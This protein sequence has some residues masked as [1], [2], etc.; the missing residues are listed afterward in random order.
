MKLRY[1][2]KLSGVLV[3]VGNGISVVLVDDLFEL[4]CFEY[5]GYFFLKNF[6]YLDLWSDCMNVGWVL[7]IKVVMDMMIKN[8]FI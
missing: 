5:C 8:V 6:F 2:R 7:Y 3:C 1:D 4:K